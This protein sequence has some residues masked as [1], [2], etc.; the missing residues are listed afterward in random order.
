MFSWNVYIF[1]DLLF[2]CYF[3]CHREF[4]YLCTYLMQ[5]GSIGAFFSDE[6]LFFP[7]FPG[8]PIFPVSK[9]SWSKTFII[10]LALCRANMFSFFKFFFYLQNVIC[11]SYS[12]FQLSQI[13]L[14][15][16][17][18]NVCAYSVKH[19]ESK[20]YMYINIYPSFDCFWDSACCFVTALVGEIE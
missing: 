19:S 2:S 15:I 18:W 3:F 20:L 7:A 14:Y 4:I 10:V 13:D 9:Q 12:T 11:S 8:R 1:H 6:M 16:C 5:K 17:K